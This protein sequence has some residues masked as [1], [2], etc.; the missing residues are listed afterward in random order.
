[1]ATHELSR[2]QRLFRRLV[3]APTFAAMEA[4]SRNWFVRCQTC[5]HRRSIWE[6]GGIRYNAAG[7]SLTRLHCPSCDS[8]RMHRL[9][10]GENFPVTSVPTGSLWRA[11]L[12]VNIAI[13]AVVAIILLPIFWAVGII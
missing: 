12:L 9:E 7:S 11:V 2:T 5:D 1:M 4:H 8:A 10:K 13:L 3:D 6:L